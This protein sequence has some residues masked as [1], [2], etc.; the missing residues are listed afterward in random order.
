MKTRSFVAKVALAFALLASAPY[1][2]SQDAKSDLQTLVERVRTKMR[3]NKRSAAELAPE[4]TAF[5]ALV[6]KYKGEKGLD[7]TGSVR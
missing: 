3:D 6:E 1:A 5:D 2:F 4:I 7:R